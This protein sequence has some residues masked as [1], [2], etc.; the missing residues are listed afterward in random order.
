M[1]LFY[2]AWKHKKTSGFLTFSEGIEI[3]LLE[4]VFAERLTDERQNLFPA[5]TIT[6][7]FHHR[8]PPTR[9]K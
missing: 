9:R 8:K 2:I 5:R 3:K 1:F 7:S 6:R 4:I